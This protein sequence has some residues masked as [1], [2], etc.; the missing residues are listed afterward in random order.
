[1]PESEPEKRHFVRSLARGLAVMRALGDA[2]PRTVAE[3]AQAAGITRAAARR[4]LLTLEE[5]GYVAAERGRYAL[6]PRTLE[7]GYA[8]LSSLSLPE[9]AQPHLRA[10]VEQVR[11]SSSVSILDGTDVVYVARVPAGRIMTVQ[12]NVGTRFPAY[13]TSMGRVLLAGLGS[14]ELDAAIAR[15]DF[16][17]L[18]GSTIQTGRALRAELE[19]VRA[20]GFSI[21]DGEL[22][23]GLLAIAVPIHNPAGRVIAAANISTHSS[24]AT[25][26]K[27]ERELLAPLR[28]AATRI[29]RELSAD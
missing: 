16:K 19:R 9:L 7:L 12:I 8:Y 27:A 10:L 23:E 25:G 3:V 14:G 4:F 22:E 2:R 6:T 29:E 21:V 18:T 11:E 15:T 1:M 13:A 20:Q 28:E 24:R 26:G 5:L 17:R